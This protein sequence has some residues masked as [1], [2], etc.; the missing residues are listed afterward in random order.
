MC[1]GP[2]GFHRHTLEVVATISKIVVPLDDDKPFNKN[3]GWTFQINIYIK[4]RDVSTSPICREKHIH[5]GSSCAS[6]STWM[7]PFKGVSIGHRT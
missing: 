7:A 4:S 6:S 2:M 5:V 3:D 1:R